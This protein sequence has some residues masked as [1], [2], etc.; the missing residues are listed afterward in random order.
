MC[1][2]C[3]SLGTSAAHA[4]LNATLPQPWRTVAPA[5][6][7]GSDALM[8]GHA[9][10]GEAVT[11]GFPLSAAEYARPHLMAEELAQFVSFG[12]AQRDAARL[13]LTGEATETDPG[14]RVLA[15]EDFTRLRFTEAPGGD[16]A[17]RFGLV[18]LGSATGIAF[19]PG[20]RSDSGD[21][22]MGTATTE[23]DPV[24]GDSSFRT[25]VHEIGH[26]LG[27][28]HPHEVAGPFPTLDRAQD[29]A[30][31]SVMS[32]VAGPG[33]SLLASVLPPGQAPES[34]MQLDIQALQRL[35]GVNWSF[36]ATDTVYRWDMTTGEMFV[37][38]VGQGVPAGRD[39]A[40]VFATL[41][42]GGGRDLLDLSDAPGPVKADLGPGGW[43][44]FSE[45]LL[46][47]LG[48]RDMADR[49]AVQAPG[50]IALALAPGG[51]PRALFEDVTGG[52]GAD[53]LVGNLKANRLSSGGGDD[54]VDGL[55]G[56]DTLTG[57][58]GADT[59]RGGEGRDVARYG[60]G[61]AW[62]DL[63]DA[64][65]GAGEGRGDVLEG[66]EVLVFGAGGN[67]VRGGAG[68]ELIQAGAGN[69]TL[70]PG[71]GDTLDGGSGTDILLLPV[72]TAGAGGMIDVSDQTR[73]SGD[74]A[75]LRALRIEGWWLGAGADTLLG[76]GVAEIV[77]TAAGDDLVR[78]AGGNDRL[79]AGGGRDTL[80]GGSGHDRLIGDVGSDVLFGGT[81]ADT[82]AGQLLSS[83]NFPYGPGVDDDHLA[84]EAGNDSLHGG[85]GADTLEGGSGQDTL[86]GDT[87]PDTLDG[88]T[89]HDT[90]TG[91]SEA[92][93]LL[94]GSGADTLE[95]GTG[96]D[97][98]DGGTGR[99]LAVITGI[100]SDASTGSTFLGAVIDLTDQ[101]ANANAA[102]GKLFLSVERFRLTGVDD[103]F[104]GASAAEEIVGA[105]GDD[106]LRGGGGADT[107]HG[108]GPQGDAD[109][110][111]ADLFV[112]GSPE[113]GG[114]L[115]LDFR[116]SEDLETSDWIGLLSDGFDGLEPGELP[117]ERLVAGVAPVA[118]GAFGTLL[119]DSATGALSWDG[120]GTG[121]A[122]PQLL[123]TLA[124]APELRP[125]DVVIL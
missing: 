87:G 113:E 85:G 112:Y 66:I 109:S 9:W 96:H 53:T 86:V 88:G 116:T 104:G 55:A 48:V 21:V 32:Y 106:E 95:G 110:P 123:A 71:A 16:A 117:A 51:N 25:L 11:Y 46:A 44:T 60:D 84:G 36:R 35:Y 122:A 54:L 65:F 52:A 80:E 18:P 50:N 26:A 69:D 111:E 20:S 6:Q 101:A 39:A 14:W 120:D 125:V 10:K 67:R 28:K 56:K 68:A 59:L 5:G 41:W 42:D 23:A 12:A 83:F 31:N 100:A 57:G 1:L 38:G 108:T 73:N 89:G 45:E 13:V 91:G 7:A 82:L 92:D 97:T 29:F 72:T 103:V 63:A 30:A 105:G 81:G 17:M 4:L 33:I 62:L 58:F 107:L 99:D 119:Y 24:P 98:L 118:T 75:G 121:T 70:L 47:Y 61:L 64:G 76:T 90:L 37:D 27:L 15:V 8:S 79:D 34:W 102:A 115:I 43:T 2:A 40:R 124:G 19:Y 74:Y 3:A 78:A 22:F 93:L 49:Q 77:H 94:G 114:D